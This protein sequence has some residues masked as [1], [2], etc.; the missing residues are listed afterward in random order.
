MKKNEA[1]GAEEHT[2]HIDRKSYEP[3]YSQLANLLRRQ[4]ADGV[5]SPGDRLPS[6]AELRERYE[7]S[8][9]TVRRAIN[10]L[11]DQN[12]VSTMQG[13]GTF[14][15]RL[16]L[17]TAA[18]HLQNVQNL[19]SDTAS[20]TVNLLDARIV[21]A[22]ES[23]AERL[24]LAVGNN[25]IYLKRLLMVDD[26]PAF[27]HREYLVYDPARPIVEAEMEATSLEG[28]FDIGSSNILK[29]GELTVEAAIM[30]EEEAHILQV[31]LPA[32]AFRLEHVFF[33]FDE[34]PTSWGWF[35]CRSDRL[36]LTTNVGIEPE[37]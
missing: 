9:M 22:D 7:V 21:S 10:T 23:I 13:L 20:A 25:T 11:V 17:G 35:V 1:K 31:A 34:R 33:D 8:P 19:L 14:V 3:A 37:E 32:A 15:R 18:F 30:S 36:K 26:E 12:V 2:Y 28:L 29:R 4:I 6:E 24:G 27:F 16:D 5:F